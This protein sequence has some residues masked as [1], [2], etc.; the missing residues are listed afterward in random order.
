[1]DA[2][3]P[4]PDAE[5]CVPPTMTLEELDESLGGAWMVYQY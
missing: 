4:C 3:P 1:M 5:V 2:G